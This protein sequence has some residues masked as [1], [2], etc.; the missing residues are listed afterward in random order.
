MFKIINLWHLSGAVFGVGA[1]ILLLAAQALANDVPGEYGQRDARSAAVTDSRFD[2][3]QILR[4]G[5][6]EEPHQ[7]LLRFFQ[8]MPPEMLETLAPADLPTSNLQTNFPPRPR[9]APT[10]LYA[11]IVDAS[12]DGMPVIDFMVTDEFGS[13][14]S[15]LQ[16]GQ[17]V[18]FSF[19]VSKLLPGMGGKNANWSTYMRSTRQ[20]DGLANGAPTTYA[21][22]TAEDLGNGNYRFTFNHSLE[23]IS[24]IEYEPGL[25]HRVGMEIRSANVGGQGIPNS[26]TYDTA[27][28]ILPATGEIDGIDTR[29]IAVQEDC[30]ACHGKREDFAFHGGARKDIQQCVSCHQPEFTSSTGDSIDFTI[31]VHKIHAGV[32]LSEPFELCGFACRQGG[33]PVS[34]NHVT[35]PQDIKNCVA[36]HDPANP[37]TPEADWVDNRATAAVC[38]SCHDSLTFDET[39]LTNLNRNHIGLAQPDSTCVACHSQSGF[40]KSNLEYHESEAR[41]LA[42]QFQFNILE[43]SNSGEGQSPSVTF[44]VTNPAN[45]DTPYDLTSHPAFAGPGTSISIAFGW[46]NT[47][48]TNV[49]N[50]DGTMTTGREVAQPRTFSVVTSASTLPAGVSDNG[51][52]TYTLD[53]S[54][55]SSPLVV[56]STTPAL[57]SGTVAMQGRVSGEFVTQVPVPGATRAF[58][59]SDSQP[60]PRRQIVSLTKCQDCHGVNDALTFH[61]SQRNDNLEACSTCHNPNATDLFRRPADPDGELNSENLAALD[62]LE[63]QSISFMY[64]IHAIHAADVREN[65][66]VAYGFSGGHDFSAITYPRPVNDCSACHMDGTYNL[67]LGDVL[68][69]TTTA[70]ATRISGGYV[71]GVAAAMDPTDDNKISPEA[72]ACVSCHDSALAMDHM[73]V[74]GESSISFGNSF[75]LN[76]DPNTDPDTQAM[77][78]MAPPE[79][80]AFC[81]GPSGFAPVGPAHGQTN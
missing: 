69:T 52:G 13:G 25:T 23:E 6:I 7:D 79:N 19:T 50:D 42:R 37:E 64:M 62:G 72:A 78:D 48:F 81:H 63:D 61:G 59:I 73:S 65:P 9:H 16:Q 10:E 18:A 71:P 1:M 5:S 76:P 67:P 14:V 39:G 27:F 66:F 58:A 24:G 28:D 56:P 55:L 43:V 68:G 75:L 11:T 38:A 8:N 47:D 4:P 26:M 12:L 31:M 49:G 41:M 21:S 29:R 36:C 60:Q 54:T 53:T 33:A 17:T 40:L 30:A 74:R 34:F 22:G 2:R 35:Y 32:G 3:Q 45:G 80:C 57:G 70:N 46:P 77:I 44:S 20:P 15:G 51:D